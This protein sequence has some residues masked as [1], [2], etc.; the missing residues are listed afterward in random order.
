MI[1]MRSRDREIHDDMLQW[2]EEQEID[3]G[4]CLMVEL[5]SDGDIESARFH[6]R[7]P[8][9][10]IRKFEWEKYVIEVLKP[11]R[12]CPWPYDGNSLTGILPQTVANV[13]QCS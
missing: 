10:D 4:R 1:V 9:E 12:P 3:P 5:V 11:S 2:V 13:H 7:R 8:S 6:M